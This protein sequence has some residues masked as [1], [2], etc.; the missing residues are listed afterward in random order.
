MVYTVRKLVVNDKIDELRLGCGVNRHTAPCHEL[1]A[2]ADEATPP[3]SVAGG[4]AREP[5]T[6]R[7]PRVIRPFDRL[8][9][10]R[11]TA[12]CARALY[13][14]RRFGRERLESDEL[15]RRVQLSGGVSEW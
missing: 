8:K 11:S 3:R 5:G 6:D 1:K 13:A 12:V 14:V 2:V 4:D 15:R 9:K 7:R 10:K